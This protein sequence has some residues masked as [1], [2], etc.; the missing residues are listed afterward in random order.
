[1]G[2]TSIFRELGWA[3]GALYLAGRALEKASARRLRIIKYYLV[4][5]PIGRLSAKPMRPDTS[6]EITVV[7]Q[8]D[9]HL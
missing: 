5:Q 8:D 7:L 9:P 4:A 6:T 1:M 2:V 3:D